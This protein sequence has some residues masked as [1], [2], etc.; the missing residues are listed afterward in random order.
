[1]VRGVLGDHAPC[2]RVPRPRGLPGGEVGLRTAQLSGPLPQPG[3]GCDRAP[4]ASLAAAAA[5][6][7]LGD[8][9][10][11]AAAPAVRGEDSA[12]VED[13]D[14]EG[15]ARGDRREGL[16][17]LAGAEVV[18]AMNLQPGAVLEQS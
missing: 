13:A 6:L 3:R 1:D 15:V 8:G 14:P 9:H 18:I 16:L 2:L 10:V 12:L 17:P 7:P 5:V 11:G 4:A